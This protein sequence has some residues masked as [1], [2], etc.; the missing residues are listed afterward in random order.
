VARKATAEFVGTALLL[1]AIVGS[2]IAAQRLSP[3]DPGLQLLENALATGFALVAIILAVGSVSGGHL[4]PVVSLVDSLLG[5][6]RR[7]DLIVY[8][9]AQVSGAVCGA[10]VANVMFSLPAVSLSSHVRSG[11]G[12]WVG[13]I[14]ATFALV[15]IIFGVARSG[16]ASLAPFAVGAWIAGAYFFTSS[17]SFANPAVSAARMLSDSFAGIAPG[18]VPAFVA[19]QI[20][21]GALGC[22]V[23]RFLWPRIREVAD[24]VVV[25][26]RDVEVA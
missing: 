6:L 3:H 13:E 21:G 17:T 8:C 2:G 7:R 24:A 15:L 20:A 11:A 9:V 12:L 18:S 22:L 23:V 19:C 25:P 4:N 26:H 10:T 5:G 14:V 1:I 16:R